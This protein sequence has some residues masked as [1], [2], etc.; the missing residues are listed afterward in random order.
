MNMMALDPNIDEE[1]GKMGV[2]KGKISTPRGKIG[3]E[4]NRAGLVSHCPECG[5]DHL[6][7]DYD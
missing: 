1:S 3:L 7:E 2:T 6:V 4:R 5:S